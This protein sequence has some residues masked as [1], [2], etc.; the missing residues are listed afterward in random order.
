MK[1]A[2]CG[3]EADKLVKCLDCGIKI[4]QDCYEEQAG[5]CEDCYYWDY[6]Q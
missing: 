2:D 1:C 3:A 5:M 4:C 6:W